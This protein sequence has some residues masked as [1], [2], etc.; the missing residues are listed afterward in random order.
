MGGS[1]PA[2][3]LRDAN[4]DLVVDIIMFKR[5]GYCGQTCDAVKRLIVDEKIFNNVVEKLKDRVS[6]IIIGQPEDPKTQMGP[7]ASK[8]Q[9]I[10]LAAQVNSSVKMGAKVITEG[11]QSKNLKGAYYLPTILTNI[12]REMPV[13]KEEVF[14]PVL[15]VV[16]FNNINEAIKMA[17]DTS[18]GLSAQVYS[19]NI[20]IAKEIAS[21]LKAGNVDINGINHFKPFVP[22]GGCKD[23]GM[24]REH[25]K[26]G[27]HPTLTFRHIT[28]AFFR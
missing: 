10:K 9:L 23:S 27:F 3:V 1:N 12:T 14:G 4:L 8:N 17:N 19:E 15:P 7:L 16:K 24:G 20:S 2:V 13:W 6:K 21:E 28:S 18:F 26:V 25:G 11:K 22:F 5:F